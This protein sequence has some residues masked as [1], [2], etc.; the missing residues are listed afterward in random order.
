MAK[1]LTQEEK[2]ERYDRIKRAE[3]R[4]WAKQALMLAKAKEAGITVTDA[5]IDEYMKQK[6]WA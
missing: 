4:S 6:G 3:R 5:E 2:A 1:E